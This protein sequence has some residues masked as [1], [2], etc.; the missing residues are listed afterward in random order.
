MMGYPKT[1]AA[2]ITPLLA[3]AMGALKLHALHI[4][5]PTAVPADTALA[6]GRDAMQRL[7]AIDPGSLLLAECW[8]A[9]RA[10]VAERLTVSVSPQQDGGVMA[11]VLDAGQHVTSAYGKTPEA[12][13]LMLTLSSQPVRST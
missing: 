2:R 9:A 4:E 3:D 13:A 8:Q 6:V 11:V 12:L 7:Q 5:H 10:V 1:Q